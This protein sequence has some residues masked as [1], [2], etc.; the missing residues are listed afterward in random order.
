[1][2][3]QALPADGTYILTVRRNSASPVAYTVNLS[4][5]GSVTALSGFNTTQTGTLANNSTLPITLMAPAGRLVYIDTLLQNSSVSYTLKAPDNSTVT[6]GSLGSDNGPFILPHA[7]DAIRQ[8]RDP[9]V[10]VQ[11]GQ[12][13]GV[14]TGIERHECLNI[15]VVGCGKIADGHIEE[16]QKLGSARVLAVCDLEPILAEQIWHF[17]TQF[18]TAIRISIRCCRGIDLT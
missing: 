13:P 9:V 2:R 17:A 3:A 4:A 5:T 10:A 14:E 1:M 8:R 18:H 7:I 16:I 15:G 12:I 11:T 6:T